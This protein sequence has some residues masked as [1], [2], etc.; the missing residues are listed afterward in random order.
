MKK[1]SHNLNKASQ[2]PPEWLEGRLNALDESLHAYGHRVTVKEPSNSKEY[3]VT[4]PRNQQ[5]IAAPKKRFSSKKKYTITVNYGYDTHSIVVSQR[6]LDVIQ[7]GESTS[8]EGQGFWIEG[9]ETQDVWNFNFSDTGS[10]EVDGEDGRQI[11]I[12][13]LNSASISDIKWCPSKAKFQAI[14]QLKASS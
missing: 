7:S 12:G 10:M 2:L 11:Y 5:S 9:T 8:I 14:R 3:T 1:N 4:F 13:K 6:Q